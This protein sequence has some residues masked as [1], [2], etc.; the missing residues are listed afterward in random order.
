MN[1]SRFAH[2]VVVLLLVSAP[3][4][5]QPDAFT[6]LGHWEAGP[7][8]GLDIQGF[9]AYH[10]N[11][12]LLEIVDVSDP[13]APEP[14]GRILLPAR[15]DDV[16]VA[17][18]LAY[19]ADSFWGLQI[20]DVADPTAPFLV[21]SL[22]I[23]DRSA[24][25]T[26]YDDHVYLVDRYEGLRVI[27]VSDPADP[28]MVHHVDPVPFP[29]DV[30]V[31]DDRVYLS[32]W[33]GVFLYDA[34]DP[35][36]LVQLSVIPEGAYFGYEGITVRDD[37]VYVAARQGG[38][39][40][41]D[42]SDPL[43]PEFL[44][45]QNMSDTAVDV[46]LHG[47]FAVVTCYHG[48]IRVVDVTKPRDL[49]IVGGIH[50]PGV[51]YEILCRRGLAYIA[52]NV[53]GVRILDLDDPTEPQI[54]NYCPVGGYG[55]GLEVRDWVA[56]VV[57]NNGGLRTLDVTDPT[58]PTPLGYC[59]VDDGFLEIAMQG[60]MA[61]VAARDGVWVFDIADP[62]APSQVALHAT[63]STVSDIAVGDDLACALFVGEGCLVLDVSD[64]AAPTPHGW[65]ALPD[66]QGMARGERYTYLTV[67]DYDHENGGVYIVDHSVSVT[68]SIVG[69]YDTWKAV[70]IDAAGD[71]VYFYGRGDGNSLGVVVLDVAD[72]TR[73]NQIGFLDL[74]W[75]AGSFSVGDGYLYLF[76]MFGDN[77][78]AIDVSDPT[79][80]QVASEFERPGW[81]AYDIHATGGLV[82]VNGVWV[83]RHDTVTGIAATPALPAVHLFQ[84]APNPFN[85]TTTIRYRL[86]TAS[87]VWL[88]VFDLQGR[89]V[90]RLRNGE[91]VPA[92]RHGAVWDG[93]DLHGR[94]AATGTYLY[95]LEAAG[96][97]ESRTMA[98]VR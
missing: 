46:D 22:V 98:L 24:A 87:T 83:L 88:E 50:P 3:L 67:T 79:A 59:R 10:G 60:D 15:I 85:P 29:Q 2:A 94:A 8:I 40:I 58:T 32:T 77:L 43:H 31:V 89:L 5:A 68:P 33:N 28:F 37:L 13:Y 21:S 55:V 23:G 73:P 45:D 30:V 25:L 34:S 96:I 38:L 53:E 35:T 27:D 51:S 1:A 82:Y 81:R 56:H 36:D 17:G 70:Q 39:R 6:V 26:V 7:C 72:P 80:P 64:P 76:Q 19:V 69:R 75:P 11:G 62:E 65:L 97:N 93:R 78:L 18:T 52:A 48:R 4:A 63:D 54:V 20:V 86:P 44:D 90:C 14:E 49:V 9:R 12:C 92:G 57:E 16:V 66:V 61:Y 74:D 84:N 41:W 95:R 71:L 47:D 42:V 91:H